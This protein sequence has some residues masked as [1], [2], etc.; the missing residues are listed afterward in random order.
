MNRTERRVVRALLWIGAAAA[1]IGMAS[2]HWLGLVVG[3][4][5]VGSLEPTLRRGVL[6]GAAFGLLA[7]VAFAGTLF[8]DGALGRFLATGGLAGLS[9][10]I[11]VGLGA[12][13]GLARALR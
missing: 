3:G 6:A 4:M 10:A 9:A 11:A 5:L 7:W 12:F 8:V 1:G 13:G 2:A